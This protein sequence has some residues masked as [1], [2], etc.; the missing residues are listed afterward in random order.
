MKVEVTLAGQ[1]GWRNSIPTFGG[2]MMERNLEESK[3][4]Q[5]D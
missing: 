2:S 5:M 1:R 4:D 3:E